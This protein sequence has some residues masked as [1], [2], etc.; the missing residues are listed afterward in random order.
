[1]ADIAAPF[2]YWS[3]VIEQPP[4]VAYSKEG[5]KATRSFI[6]SGCD[7]SDPPGTVYNCMTASMCPIRGE[8]HPSI[9]LLSADVIEAEAITSTQVKVT[10]HYALLS[11]VTQEPNSTSPGLL[12]ISAGVQSG[13]TSFDSSGAA[14]IAY[15]NDGGYASSSSSSSGNPGWFIYSLATYSPNSPPT[16]DGVNII[17]VGGIYYKKE[18][19]PWNSIIADM[20]IPNLTFRFQRREAAPP[21]NQ[22]NNYVGK[23]NEVT[24]MGFDPM[25]VLMTRCEAESQDEGYSYIVTREFQYRQTDYDTDQDPPVQYGGWT[26]VGGFLIPNNKVLYDS[27]SSSSSGMVT[28]PI[29]TAGMQPQDDS[30]T[31]FDVYETADFNDFNLWPALYITTPYLPD[32]TVGGYYYFVIFSTGGQPPYTYTA[33]GLP[34]GLS[35][36]SV[37]NIS[38]TASSPGTYTVNVVV[39][40]STPTTPLTTNKNLS[41]YM[42]DNNSESE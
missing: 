37:G 38:G 22:A 24:F 40:D 41:L 23:V 11:A 39:T 14:L 5:W 3:D 19:A 10:V 18:T 7:M 35:M 17:N 25:T 30:G 33:T 15:Y 27:G 12:T 16:V 31:L 1:M 21:L 4:T 6:F 8:A 20:Q 36:S 32:G 28:Y 13:N 26:Y 29:G 34:A 2:V 9:P 42:A